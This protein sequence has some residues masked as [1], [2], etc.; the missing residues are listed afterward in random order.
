MKPESYAFYSNYPAIIREPLSFIHFVLLMIMTSSVVVA[1]AIMA[2]A[3]FLAPVIIGGLV[4]LTLLR[5]AG[6]MP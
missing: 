1:M 4:V 5:G 3:T 2:V 6:V